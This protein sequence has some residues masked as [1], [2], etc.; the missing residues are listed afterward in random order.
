MAAKNSKSQGTERRLMSFKRPE[1]VE[2][3]LVVDAGD[4]VKLR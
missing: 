2:L 3:K 4:I 1:S